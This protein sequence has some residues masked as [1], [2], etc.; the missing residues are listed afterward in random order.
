M[1]RIYKILT[2][3]LLLVFLI[4]CC[5]AQTTDKKPLLLVFTGVIIKEKEQKTKT[6]KNT[7]KTTAP[8]TNIKEEPSKPLLMTC[9]PEI[10]NEVIAQILASGKV[11]V[12]NYNP[13]HAAIQRAILEKRIKQDAADNPADEKNVYLIAKALNADFALRMQGSVSA[14]RVD[15]ALEM[16]DI[17]KMKKWASSS[18]S[19]IQV[20]RKNAIFNASS[21]AVS[22]ILISA[23]GQKEMLNSEPVVTPPITLPSVIDAGTRNTQL[24]VDK[25][26]QQSDVAIE[27]K[28]IPSAIFALRSAI[29]LQPGNVDLRIKL[30]ELYQSI[31]LTNKAIDEYRRAS[32]LNRTDTRIYNQLVAIYVKTGKFGEAAS[33]LEEAIR[34]DPKNVDALL[35]LGDIYWNLSK[36]DE[37]EKAYINASLIAPDDSGV[38]EKLYKLYYAK[39]EYDKAFPQK[40]LSKL[41]PGDDT[42]DSRYNVLSQVIKDEYVSLTKKLY[43]S[44]IEFD[45]QEIS[46]EDYY[47]E[48]KSAVKEI[49]A[50]SDFVMKQKAPAKAAIAH[51]HALLAVNL[52]SQEYGSMVSYFETEKRHY[53][54]QAGVFSSEAQTEMDAY[55]KELSKL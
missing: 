18:G 28:D 41:T 16:I 35:N 13:D 31:K 39:K 48:C 27:K 45:K 14:D 17:H 34:I 19:D 42:D 37:A 38:H 55:D 26:V 3:I 51:S 15:M 53:L 20:S 24:E 6:A 25:L 46:R 4:S 54:D 8:T 30:A 40:Y 5:Q 33:Y 50:F 1:N 43:A 23:L 12:L 32:D 29:N 49:D 9:D 2:L 36:I 11:D 7:D 44:R 22:Q 47:Q 52:L 21:T 10:S